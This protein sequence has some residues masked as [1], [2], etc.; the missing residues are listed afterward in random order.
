[1][2][3][4]ILMERKED[5]V[6][7]SVLRFKTRVCP[8]VDGSLKYGAVLITLE[9]L[10]TG[11][12]LTVTGYSKIMLESKILNTE[13][14]TR[15]NLAKSIIMFLNY[16][17]FEREYIERNSDIKKVKNLEKIEN[18]KLYDADLFIDDYK[19]GLIGR[20]IQKSR[21]SVQQIE[22]RIARFCMFLVNNYTMKNM[23]KKDFKFATKK[24]SIN[25]KVTEKTILQSPFKVLYPKQKEKQRLEDVSFYVIS[26]LIKL[27]SELRPMFAFPIAIQSFAGLRAGEVCNV[28]Y[29]N[30]TKKYLG[31]NLMEFKINLMEEQQL[32]SDGV[33]VGQIKSH[34]IAQVHPAFLKFFDI[35]LKF[36]NEYRKKLKKRNK[37]GAM[38]LNRDGKAMT[39]K[40]Y[41][42]GFKYLVE[43]LITRLQLTGDSAAISE[44]NLMLFK[45]F[46]PHT[47]RY[48]FSQ[49]IA[50]LPEANIFDVAM[51]RRDRTLDAAINY[52][53]KNPYL[54][55][56]KIKKIQESFIK[57]LKK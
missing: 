20:N 1:M 37:F 29:Y 10:I 33:D 25:G 8:I 5:S 52:I 48:F 15:I 17:F 4:I 26:E 14:N 18:L 13:K 19:K 16:L 23:Q 34:E 45:D 51:F 12:V 54:I 31:F 38:F 27:A 3:N 53:R 6:N 47:L 40:D 28:S 42:N 49:S 24:M 41:N 32:R 9:N 11:Q 7:A 39:E 2:S 43:K 35:V 50:S 56:D 21:G 22:H 55:D 36:H 30:T 44:A 57:G 46:N